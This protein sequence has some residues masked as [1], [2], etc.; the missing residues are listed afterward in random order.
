MVI[1]LSSSQTQRVS[2]SHVVSRRQGNVHDRLIFP[3]KINWNPTFISN[4]EPQ[5]VGHHTKIFHSYVWTA[6]HLGCRM[7]IEIAKNDDLNTIPAVQCRTRLKVPYK[8]LEFLD[9]LRGDAQQIQNRN[10]LPIVATTSSFSIFRLKIELLKK[11][12][13]RIDNACG[14]FA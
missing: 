3:Y 6:V 12:L 5:G 10:A 1:I 14:S 2:F 8:Y 9:R 13:T 11:I 4:Y 7:S